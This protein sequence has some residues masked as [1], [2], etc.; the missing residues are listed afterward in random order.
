M[1]ARSAQAAERFNWFRLLQAPNPRH[2]TN[3]LPDNNLSGNRLSDMN[4]S[5]TLNKT[6]YKM[7]NKSY[8]PMLIGLELDVAVQL[9]EVSVSLDYELLRPC[10]SVGVSAL[11]LR[12]GRVGLYGK[13]CR[14]SLTA[15]LRLGALALDGVSWSVFSFLYVVGWVNVYSTHACIEYV[16][17]C[18]CVCVCVVCSI[19]IFTQVRVQIYVPWEHVCECARERACKHTHTHTHTHTHK[20]SRALKT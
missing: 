3:S 6:Y 8:S 13:A 4:L 15:Q 14:R 12:M 18:V 7:S 10:G 2:M 19:C 16:D 5:G 9:D 17:V 20:N 11:R 1:A